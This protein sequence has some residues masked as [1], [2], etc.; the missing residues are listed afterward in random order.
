MMIPCSSCGKPTVARQVQK[1]VN[2][3]WT[4]YECH[5]GC[6]KPGTNYKLATKPNRMPQAPG[7]GNNEGV[8]ILRKIHSELV[9]IRLAINSK[10]V[11]AGD[12]LEKQVEE[13]F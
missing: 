9:A 8:E 11:L 13:P 7:G 6:M 5:N 10:T 2:G 12:P 4:A 1:G 3:P